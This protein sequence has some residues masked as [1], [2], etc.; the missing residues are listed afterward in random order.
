MTS[1]FQSQ[2]V[3]LD[4]RIDHFKATLPSLAQ[5]TSM[6]PDVVR[7]LITIHMMCHCATI[8]LHTP[9][10]QSHQPSHNKII[11]AANM[12]ASSLQTIPVP[13]LIYVDPI[14]G[15]SFLYTELHNLGSDGTN[16]K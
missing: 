7:H 4:N 11:A 9:F 10:A 12:A 16:N 2:F 6:R 5:A 3:A 8:Q 1:G 14:T 13:Q 15:V